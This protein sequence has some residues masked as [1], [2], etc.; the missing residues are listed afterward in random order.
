MVD[1]VWDHAD[2][3]NH[4]YPYSMAHTITSTEQSQNIKSF[5]ASILGRIIPFCENGCDI[6]C[7]ISRKRAYTTD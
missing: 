7:Y 2:N 6:T 4:G 5:C 1:H 3:S